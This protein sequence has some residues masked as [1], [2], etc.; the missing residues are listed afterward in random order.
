MVIRW[1]LHSQPQ[2]QTRKY[3]NKEASNK[4]GCPYIRNCQNLPEIQADSPFNLI[5]Q[6]VVLCLILGTKR[7]VNVVF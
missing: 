3:N 1:L 5:A 7:M 6:N 2:V 4:E